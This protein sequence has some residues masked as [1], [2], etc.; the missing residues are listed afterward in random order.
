MSKEIAEVVAVPV[1]VFRDL[2]WLQAFYAQQ[3]NQYDG[4]RRR[5]VSLDQFLLSF[6]QEREVRARQN[7]ETAR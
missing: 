6:L 1:Q 7:A 2:V 4:G 3:L 5:P